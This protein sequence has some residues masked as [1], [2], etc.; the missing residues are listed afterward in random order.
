M[1]FGKSKTNVDTSPGRRRNQGDSHAERPSA[2]DLSSRYA[3]RRNR[4]LTGSSSVHIASSNELNAELKSPR[5]HVHHLTN[6]RRRLLLY[7]T[8]VGAA[9]LG[10]YI[11]VS[12]LVAASAITLASLGPIPQADQSAYQSSIESYYAA[13]P[14]ERFRFLLDSQALL[15]HIQA[16]RPEVRSIRIEPG[17][18]PGE[19]SVVIAARQPIA[20]WSIDG[21]NR[22]VD[23]DG[24]VFSRN[25]FSDPELQIVD[26]SGLQAASSGLVAS[27]RFLGFIGRV[28]A[29]S[30]K[31][32]L[33][34]ETVAIP[35]L[36]TRQVAVTLA[37]QSTEYKL[38]VDRS[39]GNQVEDIE[40]ISRY[41]G[42]ANTKPQYVDVRI[43]GKAFY[44]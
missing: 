3:F 21:A 2:A 8:A 24:V 20:R 30:T 9:S 13:R 6:V 4:T 40:R 16:S 34:V 17:A 38:S 11:L 7:F 37:G 5:A 31:Y 1:K 43:A 44:K 33:A 28:V 10:L 26:N 25:Y 35:S 29:Q 23:G 27:N 41:L 32:G 18:T 19:A 14:V 42:A 36:T 15:S 12:Q 22:Y 39:A